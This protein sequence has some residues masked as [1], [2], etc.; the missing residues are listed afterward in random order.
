MIT[1]QYHSNAVDR[2][3]EAIDYSEKATVC[4]AHRISGFHYLIKDDFLDEFQ[5]KI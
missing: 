5:Q 4:I 1:A 3:K 2:H